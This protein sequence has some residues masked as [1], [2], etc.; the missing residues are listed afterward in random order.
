MVGGEEAV[1][2]FVF[3][4]R[5]LLDYLGVDVRG[6]EGLDGGDKVVTDSF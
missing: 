3:E 6:A 5:F 1:E 4:E 2:I